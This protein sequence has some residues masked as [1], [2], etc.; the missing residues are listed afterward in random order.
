MTIVDRYATMAGE[1]DRPERLFAPADLNGTHPGA[2]THEGHLVGYRMRWPSSTVLPNLKNQSFIAPALAPTPTGIVTLDIRDPELLFVPSS[3]SLTG[4][5]DPLT[6]PLDH[7]LCYKA[8]LSRGAPGQAQ[9][10]LTET[11]QFET[12]DVPLRRIRWLCTP[13]NKNGEDP[14]APNHS[15]HLLCD[16]QA[17]RRPLDIQPVVNNQFGL[18][19]LEIIRREEVC[20]AVQPVPAP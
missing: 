12:M 16:R 13:A 4:P 18:Q 19:V 8:R 14:D 10:I 20:F 15:T 6:Q 3:K 2:E 11:S 17:L 5:P 9:P 7:F 1:A